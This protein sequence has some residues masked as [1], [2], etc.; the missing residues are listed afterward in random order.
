VATQGTSLATAINARTAATGVSASAN[1]VTGAITLSSSTGRTIAVTTNNGTA[2]AARIENATGLEVSAS[3]SSATNSVAV[4]STFST[5]TIQVS[6]FA[7]VAASDSFTVGGQTF[8]FYANGGSYSGSNIGVEIGT[9]AA[10]TAANI[11]TAINGATGLSFASTVATDTVTLTSR[12]LGTYTTNL[13]VVD[14]SGGLTGGTATAGT[15]I[16]HNDTVTVDGVQYTFKADGSTGTNF[17]NLNVGAGGTTTTLAGRLV[18]AINANRTADLTSISAAN[19]GATV[20]LTAE[21]RGTPGNAAV[22]ISGTAAG[23]G[24]LVAT[25]SNVTDG[26]Y[27]ASTTYGTISL[28]SNAAYQVGGNNP[29]AAG[30]STA[31]STLTSIGTIDI[32]SV[33]GA[34]S[35]I[36]L[37]DGALDQISKIRADLGSVQNRFESTISNLSATTE[38]LSAARSRIRDADFAQETALLTRGQILQQAGTAILAQANSLPQNVLSLLR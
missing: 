34:N 15:G 5:N 26:A 4:N 16:S 3:A 38:N 33:N 31:S 6:T 8:D 13:A 21:V 20:T 37:V 35:A 10:T 9:D 28:N 24:E 12:T 1:S 14:A 27:T 19:T 29:G 30:L 11:N 18:T 25:A 36:T 17:I 2:G 7:N 22:A 32:S 23:A